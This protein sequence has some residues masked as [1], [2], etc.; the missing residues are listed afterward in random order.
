[1]DACR[2]SVG[3]LDRLCSFARAPVDDHLDLGWA[4]RPLLRI[5][6]LA[7][8]QPDV[9][10]AFRRALVGDEEVNPAYRSHLWTVWEHPVTAL[11]PAAVAMVAPL[12][13]RMV[14]V[15]RIA[16]AASEEI[17]T[18]VG[19]LLADVDR[20]REYLARHLTAL[21]DFYDGAAERELAVILW[22]D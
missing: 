12:L 4:A 11:E 7:S 6:E 2:T 10:A 8:A 1:M 9:L 21:L 22:W 19:E 17:A 18:V 14:A 13:R 15:L 3:E 5:G 16:L 20:P